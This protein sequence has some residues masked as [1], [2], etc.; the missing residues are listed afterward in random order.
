MSRRI[1]VFSLVVPAIS[2]LLLVGCQPIQIP[3]EVP[4]PGAIGTFAVAAGEPTEAKGTIQGSADAPNIGSGR[5]QLDVSA[6]SFEPAAVPD[7]GGKLL[8]AAQ[9]GGGTLTVSVAIADADAVDTVC[10]DGDQ[11]G[12]FTITLNAESEVESISPSS[13]DL[14][15]STIAL[16]NGGSFSV[17]LE[18]TSDVDGTLTI[19]S[20]TVNVGL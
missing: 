7:G 14:K 5:L 4:L 6:I 8:A 11:Y 10:E 18:V 13:V 17:C 16:L 9:D 2:F 19:E 20:L 1:G 3:V 12:P 15:A